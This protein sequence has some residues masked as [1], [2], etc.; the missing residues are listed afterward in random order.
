MYNRSKRGC[1]WC[2][3]GKWNRTELVQVVSAHFPDMMKIALIC[4]L[5]H[6]LKYN[7]NFLYL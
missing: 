2:V 5:K 1:I 7:K 3:F 6:P 4:N